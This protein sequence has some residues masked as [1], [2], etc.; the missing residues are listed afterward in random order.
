MALNDTRLRS[1]KPNQ[2][3]AE[4]LRFSVWTELPRAHISNIGGTDKVRDYDVATLRGP[5]TE[6]F[7]R[8]EVTRRGKVTGHRSVDLHVWHL[9]ANGKP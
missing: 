3:K 7:E 8:R 2:G 1:L 5:S 6:A 9:V 4:R